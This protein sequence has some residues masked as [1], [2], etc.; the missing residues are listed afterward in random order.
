[1]KATDIPFVSHIGIKEK[2]NELSLDFN[3]NVLNH[4][5]TIH[6]S[7][8]FT[9]AETQS[10]IHLQSLF[11]ELEGKVLPILREAQIKYKKPAVEKIIAF[12]SIDEEAVKKFKIQFE[13]KARASLQ[14]N[15]EV[16]DINDIL[17]CQASF[18]WFIQ[19]L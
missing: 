18:T 3:D 15:V 1:M 10:G 8:Q 11:P 19:A 4:I 16:K 13:R 17:T 6:A 9:L 2:N 7:A 5:K 14:V 12:S